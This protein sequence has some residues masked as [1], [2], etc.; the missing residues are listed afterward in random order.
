MNTCKNNCKDLNIDFEKIYENIRVILLENNGVIKPYLT[1][2]HG[3]YD[4][5]HQTIVEYYDLKCGTLLLKRNLYNTDLTKE[6]STILEQHEFIDYLFE[7]EEKLEYCVSELIDYYNTNVEPKLI[8][9]IE[10]KYSDYT[11]TRTDKSK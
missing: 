6:H 11:K 1:L 5:N 4:R 3:Y 9:Y 2:V 7:A 8:E 10:T